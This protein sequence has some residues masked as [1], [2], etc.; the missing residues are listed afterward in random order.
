MTLCNITKK[1]GNNTVFSDFSLEVADKGI[2]AIKGASGCGKTTFLRIISGLDKKYSGT[3]NIG[4]IK[5]ISYVFQEPRLLENSTALENVSL[6]LSNTEEAEKTAEEWLIKV[7]LGSDIYT[8][9]SEM[10]GGMKQRV[11]IARALAFDG[12]ILLLDEAFNGIDSD[13]AKDIMDIVKEFARNKPVIFVSH[14][15]EQIEYL[16]AKVIEM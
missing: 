10:S 4:N 7:G 2:T 12:D 5:R 15:D 8:Y 3:V 1:F 11:S 6:V 9:P 14:S 13:R 16:K